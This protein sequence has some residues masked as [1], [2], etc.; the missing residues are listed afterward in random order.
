MLLLEELNN[1]GLTEVYPGELTY[2]KKQGENEEK[3]E[4]FHDELF[5]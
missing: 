4:G 3:G 5:V 2:S 1:R